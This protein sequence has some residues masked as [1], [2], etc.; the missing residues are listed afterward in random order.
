MERVRLTPADFETIRLRRLAGEP[1]RVIALDYGY[2]YRGL[3]T[4][5]A[6]AIGRIEIGPRLCPYCQKEY[7]PY[8]DDSAHCEELACYDKHR[9]VHRERYCA[10]AKERR[11]DPNYKVTPRAKPLVG[12]TKTMVVNCIGNHCGHKEFV[13]PIAYTRDGRAL[14]VYRLCQACKERNREINLAFV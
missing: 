5:V 2:S 3:M 6:K 14:P 4:K 9:Q 8:R 12:R 13:T 7:I 1:W 11:H 10:K